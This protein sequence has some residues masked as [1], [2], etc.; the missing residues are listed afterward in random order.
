[1]ETWFTIIISLSLIFL[2]RVLL[3]LLQK[4]STTKINKPFPPGPTHIPIISPLIWLTKSVSQ[5]EPIVKN[6]HAKYG[7]IVTL[8]IGSNPTVFI[9]DR[10]I[11]HQVLIQNGS[12]YADRPKNLHIEDFISSN[13]H[14]IT[15]S[16]YGTTWR[17][18]RRNLSAE[19]LHPSRVKYFAQIRKWVLDVLLKRLKSDM[20]SSDSVKAM[21]HFQHAMFSLLVFMCFGQRVDD[22]KLNDI[23]QGERNLLLSLEKFNVLN[24]WP[25]I[26]KVLF[27]KRWEDLLKLRSNQEMVLV[28][29][30]RARK[31]AKK[32]GLCYDNN[33]PRAYVDTLL[34]LKLP[35]EGQRN[36]DEGEMVTLCSEFLSAGTD[37]TSTSLQWIMANL[38]KH[39]HV[40]QRIVDEIRE[41]MAVSD[42]EEKEEVHEEDLEKLPYLK[43]VVLETLRRHP[44]THF[45][46]PHAVSEDVVLNGY[47]VPKKGSV[48]FMVAEIGRD[49]KV[50]EDPMAFKPERF[51]NED[52]SGVDQGFDITGSK[53]IK[54]MPFGAGRRICPAYNLGM[55]HLEYYV[56]NLVWNFDWKVSNGGDVDLSEKEEFTFVMKNPLEAHISPRIHG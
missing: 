10:F 26:T 56:A 51:L 44:P 33:N 39:P 29:L 22:E 16:S 4:S 9:N 27:R 20:K 2:L 49:P 35:N 13:Q 40:Q 47:L 3:S 23:E 45:L 43:A 6:L 37:T 42:K 41:V 15:S 32:S 24:Y 1:M 46:L 11:V 19:M 38:V 28:P 14:N 54:M 50:W 25:K 17:V 5:I 36:L 34:D 52:G 48:N 18:L 21:D 7:P 53:E 8:R 30:I 12:V 31:E 55:L